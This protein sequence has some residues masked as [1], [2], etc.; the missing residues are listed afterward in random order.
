MKIGIFPRSALLFVLALIITA[1]AM[2][3]QAERQ[4]DCGIAITND[5]VVITKVTLGT[6]EVPCMWSPGPPNGRGV[7]QPAPPFQADDDWLQNVTIYLFNRT[8]KSI[9]WVWVDIGF[10]QTGDG[11]SQATS[12]RTY[13]I[14]LGQ[15]PDAANFDPRTGQPMPVQGTP[16]SFAPGQTLEIHLGEHFDRIKERTRDRLFAPLT[17]VRVSPVHAFFVDGMGW[18]PS[19]YQVPDPE[20]H[21]KWIHMPMGYFLGNASANW[22]PATIGK[23]RE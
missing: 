19:S 6:K 16:L 7:Y 13:Q 17:S 15:R 9:A 4:I 2:A 12:Q 11:L 23:S 8:N 1:P 21:G 18:N 10:P 20:H 22:P 3:A 5:A 14:I